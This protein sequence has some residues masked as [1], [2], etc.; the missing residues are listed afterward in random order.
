MYMLPTP[1]TEFVVSEAGQL[2]YHK[3]RDA[4]YPYLYTVESHPL[5]DRSSSNS[6]GRN[7]VYIVDTDKVAM[8]KSLEFETG[9]KVPRGSDERIQELGSSIFFFH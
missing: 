4:R 7:I 1:G 8:K 3:S 6:S 2:L 9:L 5:I